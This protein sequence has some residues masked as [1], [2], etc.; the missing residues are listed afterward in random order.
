MKE[1][2]NLLEFE[3]FKTDCNDQHT[4]DRV[5]KVVAKLLFTFTVY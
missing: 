3:M 4:H 5:L 2:S 1:K